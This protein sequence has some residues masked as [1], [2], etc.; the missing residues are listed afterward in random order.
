MSNDVTFYA[1]QSDNTIAINSYQN[2]VIFYA[3]QLPSL[4]NDVAFDAY[5]L[6][7]I[8]INAYQV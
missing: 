5:Q 6:E 7:D 2:D 8:A 4:P 3:Y 1:Y